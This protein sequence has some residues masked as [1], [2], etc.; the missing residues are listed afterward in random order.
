MLP[1][2]RAALD[3][4]SITIT[5]V[6]L[7]AHDAWTTE[8]PSGATSYR[9]LVKALYEV[10]SNKHNSTV[11]LNIYFREEL[12]CLWG[13]QRGSRNSSMGIDAI[14]KFYSELIDVIELIDVTIHYSEHY[15]DI[16]KFS[17]S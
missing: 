7:Y 10:K 1:F 2:P 15:G 6:P 16:G 14:C 5:P 3:S 9:F 11:N 8:L 4:P 17:L 13:Q 12:I